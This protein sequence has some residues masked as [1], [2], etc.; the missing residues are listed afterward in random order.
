MNYMKFSDKYLLEFI[1][2]VTKNYPNFH[3]VS[4]NKLMNNILEQYDDFFNEENKEKIID[5]QQ[6]L[7]NKGYKEILQKE[8]IVIIDKFYNNLYYVK[9]YYL[10]IQTNEHDK[11]FIIFRKCKK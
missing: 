10:D 11:E 7:L 8:N 4:S 1:S 6:S 3:E 9:N 2:F 5:K